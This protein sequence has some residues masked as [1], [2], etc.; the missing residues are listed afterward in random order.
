MTANG[1]QT[2]RLATTGQCCH[3]RR[4]R[5][6]LHLARRSV[7]RRSTAPRAAIARP[8]TIAARGLL[9]VKGR[10]ADPCGCW[11]T[12]SA[13]ADPVAAASRGLLRRGL[14][15]WLLAPW[16]RRKS[17][18]RAGGAC[19]RNS[20][21]P[22]GTHRSR[23]S[24]SPERWLAR[25]SAERCGNLECRPPGFGGIGG[26]LA[27]TGRSSLCRREAVCLRSRRRC[28]GR[29]GPPGRWRGWGAADRSRTAQGDRRG[30][31]H[32]IYCQHCRVAVAA[33]G[34]HPARIGARHDGLQRFTGRLKR[35]GLATPPTTA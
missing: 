9:P 22:T 18:S 34:G 30:G 14:H 2:G 4:R 16:G 23:W 5:G 6:L 33:R 24:G 25:L 7:V 13:V 3:D 11:E 29:P 10:F 28:R 26:H 20:R 21:P 31:A 8:T 35:P 27:H 32:R 12:G 1:L 15:G 19:R 17:P